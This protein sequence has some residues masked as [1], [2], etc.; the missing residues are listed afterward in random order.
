MFYMLKNDS[1]IRQYGEYGYITSTGLYNDQLFDESGWLFLSCIK[2]EPQP[3]EILADQI[4]SKFTGVTTEE[5]MPDVVQFYN[6]LCEDGF[7][8]KGLT[9]DE[10]EQNSKGFSYSKISDIT[11]KEDYTPKNDRVQE[12]SQN[13]L[14]EYFIENPTIVSFQIELTSKCN[15]R[16]IHCYIPHKYKD[17]DIKPELFYSVLDQLKKM[18]TLSVALSGGEPMTHP[19]FVDFLKAAKDRDFK[20]TILSNLLLLNDK[21][22]E[23]LKN[24]LMCSIQTSLYSMN[25]ERH[26][27]ITTI[28]GSFEKTKN[29]IL[30][31]IENDIPVQISC[32]IMKANKNDYIEVAKWA[33]EHKI[34]AITDY[35][36]MAQY[37]H[38]TENLVN[39]LSPEECRKEIE[40]ILEIDLDYQNQILS[41]DFIKRC[42]IINE[43]PNEPFCGVGISSCC[44]VAN[45]NVY[46]CSGWQSYVCGNLNEK[47]L[48]EIWED[49]K[50][51]I[52]L[53]N[54]RKGDIKECLNCENK[55]F[56]SPCLSRFANE[57][58]TGNPLEVA[59]HFCEVAKVNRQVV[60]SWRK[61]KLGD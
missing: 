34:R 49:S 52:W 26:D 1:F 44:M 30:K 21:I 47:T 8:S 6:A 7:L 39:R 18:G 45:G 29:A 14:E 60:L 53:R 5:I 58:K 27:L 42:T 33:H 43:D 55:A 57:S 61:A 9:A 56:C 38:D 2:R 51:M 3:I 50:E 46:P 13:F 41:K 12:E 40:D 22:L 31:L 28:P 19:Y 10:A 24:G 37:N 11:F 32:P 36:I 59:K 16:C 4:A 20:V 35:A 17:T 23:T 48:K 25:P 54:L 15:E